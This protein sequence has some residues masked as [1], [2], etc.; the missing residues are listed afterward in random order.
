M[1]VERLEAH[2]HRVDTQMCRAE[3]L[4]VAGEL[5][6]ARFWRAVEREPRLNAHS[7]LRAASLADVRAQ[8]LHQGAGAIIGQHLR[9]PAI[10]DASHSP[11]HDIGA[12]TDPDWDLPLRWQWIDALCTHGK[13]GIQ[14]G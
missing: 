1:L 4:P 13:S 6:P 9:E 11:E 12:T 2:P 10:A 8:M 7:A 5:L 14:A 3:R